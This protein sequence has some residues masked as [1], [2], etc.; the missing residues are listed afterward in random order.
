MHV[1]VSLVLY[2][3]L[4]GC[5]KR[6]ND[7]E[8]TLYDLDP[9][10]KTRYVRRDRPVQQPKVEPTKAQT[11][12][13]KAPIHRLPGLLFKSGQGSTKQVLAPFD[14]HIEYNQSARD[15]YSVTMHPKNPHHPTVIVDGVQVKDTSVAEKKTGSLIGTTEKAAKRI[16]ERATVAPKFDHGQPESLERSNM[17][18]DKKTNATP[19]STNPDTPISSGNI[20]SPTPNEPAQKYTAPTQI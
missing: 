19:Q 12:K 6:G 15:L 4:A 18:P 9:M 8:R 5:Q 1:G 11:A 10:G 2:L 13:K 14:C 20:A 7:I 16:V 17:S 3:V